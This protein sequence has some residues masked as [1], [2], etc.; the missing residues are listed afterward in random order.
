[1]DRQDKSIDLELKEPM[2]VDNFLYVQKECLNSFFDQGTPIMEIEELY[3]IGYVIPSSVLIKKQLLSPFLFI[4][5]TK[6]DLKD[7][8]NYI[9]LKIKLDLEKEANCIVINENDM[10]SV[11]GVIGKYSDTFICL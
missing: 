5:F 11:L 2:K 3:T 8:F 7:E 1:M 4:N 9:I 6:Q 10:H